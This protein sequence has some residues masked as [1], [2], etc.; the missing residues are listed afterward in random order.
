MKCHN[1][2]SF[3]SMF[4]FMYVDRNKKLL[5]EGELAA[6]GILHPEEKGDFYRKIL[7]C[8]ICY[9]QLSRQTNRVLKGK[10]SST[11]KPLPSKT[12]SNRKID[13]YYQCPFCKTHNEPLR[14]TCKKCARVLFST[15]YET[16]MVSST[17]FNVSGKSN[18]KR[19]SF[20]RKKVMIPIVVLLAI[21]FIASRETEV[22]QL[23]A[24]KPDMGSNLVSGQINGRST[25]E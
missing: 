12:P 9:E 8:G 1:C 4:R 19:L 2:N 5:T 22:G 14:N 11:Y 17:S 10:A 25:Y 23:G 20:D 21:A 15:E 24:S 7:L 18:R 16:K 6:F 3:D 13:H